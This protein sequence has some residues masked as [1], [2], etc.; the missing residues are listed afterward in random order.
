MFVHIIQTKEVTQMHQAFKFRLYP[1]LEQATLINKSIGCCRFVFNHFLA[2]W[3]ETYQQT[4]KGLSY[5]TCSSQLTQLKKEINWLK[6]I[7]AT[8]LQNTCKHLADGFPSFLPKT[9]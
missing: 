1:T 7:D 5:H 6:E 3:N 9:E 8:S 2:Q 4:G